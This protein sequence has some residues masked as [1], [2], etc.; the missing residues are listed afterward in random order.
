MDNWCELNRT[1]LLR[2]PRDP[3]A[4]PQQVTCTVFDEQSDLIWAGDS[5]GFV[6]SYAETVLAPYTRFRAHERSVMQILSHPKGVLSTDGLTLRLTSRRG[7]IIS[8]WTK[9]DFPEFEAISR[10]VMTGPVEVLLA[11]RAG[12]VKFDTAKGM[13]TMTTPYFGDV[14]LMT[15]NKRHAAIGKKDGFIDIYDVRTG[16]IVRTFATNSTTLTDMDLKEQTLVTCGMTRRHGVFSSDPLVNVFDLR[17]MQGLAPIAFPPGAYFVRLHPKLPSVIMIASQ[18]G[19]MH[20]VD[21][22]DPTKIFLA[23][24]DV[25]PELLSF[26]ISS[27]GDFISAV[28]AFSLHHLWAHNPEHSTMSNRAPL[29]YASLPEPPSTRTTIDDDIPLNTIGMPHYRETLLSAWPT[30]TIFRS[31]GTIPKQID[32]SILESAQQVGPGIFEASYDKAKYG[33][34]NMAKKY[35]KVAGSSASGKFLSSKT[36]SPTKTSRHP[37]ASMEEDA[38][39][40]KCESNTSKVPNAF[41][42]L[43]I[44]YS[45]FGIDDFDFDY[46]NQTKFSGLECHVDNSYTN[47]LLQLYRFVPE[48]FNFAVGSLA[49]ENL[50]QDSLLTELGYLYDM[51]V[52]A[53]G[54]HFRA[55]NF[56]HTLSSIGEAYEVGIL[57]KDHSSVNGHTI[58][59]LVQRSQWFNIFLLNKLLSD[60]RVSKQP[61]GLQP[62]L[63]DILGVQIQ[64]QMRRVY[65]DEHKSAATL[66]LFLEVTSPRANNFEKTPHIPAQPDVIQYIESS[67]NRFEHERVQDTRAARYDIQETLH[68]VRRIP[69]VLSC[70]IILTSEEKRQI[71]NTRDWLKKKF[72]AG[73]SKNGYFLTEHIRGVPSGTASYFEEYELVGFVAEIS[74]EAEKDTHLVTF[75]Q[76]KA[77]GS[78]TKNWYMFNDFLVIPIPEEEALNVSYWWKT[79]VTLVYRNTNSPSEFHYDAW[80]NGLND[81]ILYRDH[82]AAGTR[83][84]KKI[85]YELLTK[86]EAPHPGSLV[87]IDTEFVTIEE[88][89]FEIRSNGTRSLLKPSNQALARV[90]V[91]RGDDGDKFAVPFI[92][93][94]VVVKENIHDYLTT[95]SGIEHGDLDPLTSDK[96]LVTR[97]VVYRKLWLLLNLGCVFVG[98]GLTKDFRTINI[99]VPK[100]QVRDTAVFFYKGQRILSLR[101]LAYVLL[102]KKVQEGNHDSIED[103]HTALML[104]KKYLKLQENN[105]F[106]ETLE[107]IYQEGQ[108]LRFKPPGEE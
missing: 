16:S 2:P 85:E 13:I 101:F 8:Q 34:R 97:Q 96:A 9:D 41:K 19:Q 3:A 74:G 49:I 47:A 68:Q 88:E 104:Y 30:Q 90:S 6:A 23:Q 75:V 18:G 107:R 12:L 87:A 22:F 53:D 45:K 72:H 55:T 58:T 83:E 26:E 52:K 70:N 82:F 39:E 33:K 81:E 32:N 31:A 79:P 48:V 25:G 84:S 42:K 78:D 24:I 100:S 86:Q 27:T 71:R 67:M 76:M 108:I 106:E 80:K 103:A 1:P 66:K 15:S 35:V 59:D 102:D 94:W 62:E 7:L 77:E 89:Q 57:E 17:T 98:H 29:D 37:E 95:Y 99:S 10:I 92:D 40:F 36:V 4:A 46:Y 14:I 38:F 73:W 11:T 93:D 21:M 91:L 44:L 60:E 5:T 65:T 50:N 51:L 61:L 54:K 43:E 105:Q 28:D 20:C 64:H 56:Q 63:G 69:T